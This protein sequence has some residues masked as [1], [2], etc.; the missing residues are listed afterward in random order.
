MIAS[1]LMDGDELVDALL[2]KGSDVNL[3]NYN[4]QVESDGPN[5]YSLLM[6]NR[7]RSISVYRK[8]IS[9]SQGSL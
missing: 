5:I 3:K 2:Q 1:S 7:Q 6:C 9:M 4:G 8:T